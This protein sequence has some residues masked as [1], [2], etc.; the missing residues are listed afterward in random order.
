[1]TTNKINMT[2][3]RTLLISRCGIGNKYI[4]MVDRNFDYSVIM[5]ETM[6][7]PRMV[8]FHM[9]QHNDTFIKKTY[10]DPFC[11]S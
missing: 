11:N 4:N 1:M 8:G 5:S 10:T 7:K 6:E 3:Y 9:Y 2:L